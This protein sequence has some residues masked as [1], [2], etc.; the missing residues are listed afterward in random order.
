MSTYPRS[1]ASRIAANRETMI[2]RDPQR[3][4]IHTTIEGA[5]SIAEYIPADQLSVG[6]QV[7]PYQRQIDERRAARY[8]KDWDPRK[9]QVI[10][11]ALRADGTLVVVDGQH[12]VTAAKLVDPAMP[13][14]STVYTDLT[15]EE[16]AALWVDL[17]RSSKNPTAIEVFTAEYM[18]DNAEAVAIVRAVR[19]AGYDVAIYGSDKAKIN[20][21][22]SLRE[23]QRRG[24]LVETLGAMRAAWG[25]KYTPKSEM[26]KGMGRFVERYREDDRYSH[27]RLVETLRNHSPGPLESLGKARGGELNISKSIAVGRLIHEYYNARLRTKKLP[28]WPI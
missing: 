1:I 11:V 3:N 12:R 23:V 24:V 5:E 27:E 8:A 15:P 6:V 19:E 7:A 13:L 16:E 26:I 10:T 20:A 18:A 17:S 4:R 22:E 28:V 9:A 21:V 25:D 2:P 14:L